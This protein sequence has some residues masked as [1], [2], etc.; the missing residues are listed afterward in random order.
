MSLKEFVR[1]RNVICQSVFGIAAAL[2]QVQVNN[3]CLCI[4]H[5]TSML[6]RKR[7]IQRSYVRGLLVLVLFLKTVSTIIGWNRDETGR[8]RTEASAG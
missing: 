6:L 3:A 4:L 1:A 2:E 7:V 8:Y 5:F